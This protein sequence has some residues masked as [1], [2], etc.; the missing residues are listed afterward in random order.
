MRLFPSS[1]W[2]IL[3]ISLASGCSTPAS[4]GRKPSSA[5]H[6]VKLLVERSRAF[7]AYR[8]QI[9]DLIQR[10]GL[11]PATD[12]VYFDGKDFP[13]FAAPSKGGPD[14]GYIVVTDFASDQWAPGGSYRTKLE[15]MAQELPVGLL[16]TLPE[17]FWRSTPLLDGQNLQVKMSFRSSIPGLMLNRDAQVREKFPSNRR[18]TSPEDYTPG[19]PFF[20]D[21][22]RNAEAADQMGSERFFSGE[23]V[24]HP[25]IRFKKGA[26]DVAKAHQEF[27]PKRV[28]DNS[29]KG[30]SSR[31]GNANVLVAAMFL[32]S[33]G[34]TFTHEQITSL[35]SKFPK[36]FNNDVAVPLVTAYGGLV[37]F[38]PGSGPSSDNPTYRF[39][40]RSVPAIRD[41]LAREARSLDNAVHEGAKDPAF[42]GLVPGLKEFES[43]SFRRTLQGMM[44]DGQPRSDAEQAQ[45]E[46]DYVA[47]T[48]KA[49]AAL[50]EAA[51]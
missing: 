47:W 35:V 42:T 11:N 27:D 17:S 10:K 46:L 30:P 33:G 32:A 41:F 12:V 6:K 45:L 49:L 43:D 2:S 28:V 48:R 39:D 34:G 44:K 37:D 16:M 38:A 22:D 14:T 24:D 31:W 26:P 8:K 20:F 21:L 36:L 50:A 40:P 4:L 23:S 51:R 29:L 3:L 25:A 7:P 9:A 13:D 5:A 19:V 18:R 1:V 15:K